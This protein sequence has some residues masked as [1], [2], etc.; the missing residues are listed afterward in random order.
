MDRPMKIL[1]ISHYFPPEIGAASARIYEIAKYWVKLGHEV[2][3]LTGFP[4]YPSGKIP[5]EYRKKVSRLVISEEIN[6]INVVRTLFYPTPYRGSFKRILNYTSFLI[7]ASITG[8]FVKKADIVVATSPPLLVGLVGYWISRLK[9]IPFVLEVRDLWP[10]SLL[11]TGIGSENSYFYKFLDRM[12]MFL[13]RKSTKIVVVTDGFKEELV[14]KKRIPSEKIEVIKNGVDSDLFRPL[15]DTERIKNELGFQGK[16]IVSYI[17][18]IGLSHGIEVVMQAARLLKMKLPDLVFL[19]V[20]DGPERER[21][22]KIKEDE[23]LSNLIFLGEQPRERIPFFI[24][25]SDI[26]LVP[27]KKTEIFRTRIPAKMFEIMAC[28]KPI[29]L[30]ADGEARKIAVEEAKAG[31]YVEPENVEGLLRAILL[32]HGNSNLRSEL[33]KNGREFVTRN[34]SRKIQAEDYLEILNLLVQEKDRIRISKT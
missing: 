32:L 3:V 24:N 8:S 10:E 6:G 16:F 12:A 5:D 1:Y 9:R 22:L 33:G 23:N 34:F 7:S 17:G 14:S 13:Y 21:V 20:G 30:T 29:I 11:G 2:M 31:L 4:N 26:C 25:A 15:P 18:T 28:E 19:I 27:L